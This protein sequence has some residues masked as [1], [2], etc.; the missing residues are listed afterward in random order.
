MDVDFDDR[1]DWWLDIL[2]WK[3]TS[4]YIIKDRVFPNIISALQEIINS[5]IIVDNKY[6][7]KTTDLSQV[8]KKNLIT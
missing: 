5:I 6:P 4:W 2:S 1:I 7:E 3:A 8:T